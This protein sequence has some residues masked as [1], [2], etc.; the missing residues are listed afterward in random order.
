MNVLSSEKPHKVKVLPVF[1]DVAPY[2]VRYQPE[3]SAYN[4]DNVH[5]ST[6]EEKKRWAKALN[7]L[8]HLMGFEYNSDT[9]F[10]WE[11]L[12]EIARKVEA[13]LS[14]EVISCYNEQQCATF[15]QEKLNQVLKVLES[16]DFNSK[17]AFL[18]G[19]YEPRRTQFA[20]LMVQKLCSQFDAF[21][22]LSNVMEESS[23]RDGL[24]NLVSKLY[25]D[26]IRKPNEKPLSLDDITMYRPHY[27]Q[28]L[29][30][31]RC[32]VVLN[33]VGNDID[34][35]RPLLQVVRENLKNRSLVVVTSQF[36][37]VLQEELKVHKFMSLSSSEDTTG[38]LLICYGNES[39]IHEA[40]I[41]E[42]QET[43]SML[44][45]DVY[46]VNKERLSID[47]KILEK[48]RVILCIT[49]QS[50]SIEEFEGMLSALRIHRPNVL[51]VSYGRQST[52]ESNSKAC[53]K[54]K[55]NF[56]DSELNKREFRAMVH[57]VVRAFNKR[58]EEI[59]EA[60]NFPVGLTERVNS[61]WTPMSSYL[62]SSNNG[63][64][65]FGIL[66]MGGVG[67]TTTALS[68][69]NKIEKQF[70]RSFFSLNTAA[71]VAPDASY[72][73]SLQREILKSLLSRNQTEYGRSKDVLHGKALLW[74]SNDE[75]RGKALLSS[76]LRGIS[77]V[78]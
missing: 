59:M 13:A 42:L 31:K 11:P 20:E 39:D 2:V 60:A 14:K 18:I 44:G 34:N 26:L 55:V 45:L 78:G 27:E 58:P 56:E 5:G 16:N 47:S 66:G 73:V 77:C 15:Y 23:P 29:R 65:C 38:I 28:L 21:C 36:Q 74:S 40:F 32:V 63:V 10:Q 53:F 6:S 52:N 33:G 19:V 54:L 50:L 7:S 35:I 41:D 51:Y 46:L 30:N 72:L 43:F 9:R 8:S 70:E 64:V 37:Y 22:L 48:S 62:L 3:G 71:R 67:K 12:D 1:F 4:L 57:E 69:Y 17:P 49:S 61:M 24:L 68:I 76:K 25:S 75:L